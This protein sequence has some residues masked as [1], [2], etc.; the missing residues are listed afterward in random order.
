MKGEM[1]PYSETELFS[2]FY[3]YSDVKSENYG[4]RYKEE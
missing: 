1:A 3:S 2:Q 4:E